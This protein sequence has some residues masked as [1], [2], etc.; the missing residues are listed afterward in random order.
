[1][2]RGPEEVSTA[3][4]AGA[5]VRTSDLADL[6]AFHGDPKIMRRLHPAREA[7]TERELAALLDE[8]LR[9]WEEHGFGMWVFRDSRTRAFLGR[10]GL[11]SHDV[12]G[13]REIEL[14]YGVSPD[15][16]GHGYATEMALG[17][18]GVARAE[19]HVRSL[20]AFT[21]PTNRASRRVLEK[22]GFRIA[23]SIVHAE[24][25]HLLFRLD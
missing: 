23:G 3:R 19:L 9:H 12:G 20:V 14:F 17:I 8:H 21:L 7:W 11:R 22:C 1:M 25:D 15:S 16:W 24:L 2:F 5:R 13:R 10:A 4:L 6:M 18:I